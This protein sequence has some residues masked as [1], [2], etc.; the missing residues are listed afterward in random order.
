[1]TTDAST[2]DE[3]ARNP[4][5]R[6]P[7]LTLLALGQHAATLLGVPLLEIESEHGDGDVELHLVV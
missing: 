7:K 6:L 5:Q 1:M 2:R 3:V 4:L